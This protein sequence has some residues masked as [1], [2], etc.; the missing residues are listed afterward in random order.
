[1]AN[2]NTEVANRPKIFSISIIVSET[3]SVM[4]RTL[5]KIFYIKASF[6]EK[7]SSRPLKRG[8]TVQNLHRRM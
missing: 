1:M 4:Q 2:K 6:F 7:R 5:F 8:E 3:P